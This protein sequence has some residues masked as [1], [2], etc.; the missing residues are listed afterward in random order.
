MSA[1][2]VELEDAYTSGESTYCATP[3]LTIFIAYQEPT[4]VTTI[5]LTETFVFPTIIIFDAFM[6][7]CIIVGSF[8][9]YKKLNYFDNDDG[10]G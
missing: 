1:E 9:D 6:L 5:G 10:N 7:I 3:H 2:W 8:F 4:T